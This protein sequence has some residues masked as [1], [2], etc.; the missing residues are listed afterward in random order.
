M[1]R[2]PSQVWM[3]HRRTG[4]EGQKGELALESGRVVFSPTGGADPTVFPIEDIR[5]AR[6]VIGSPVLELRLAARS[7]FRMV[8]FY[9]VQPPSL[10]PSDGT[11]RVMK[12]RAARKTAVVKLRTWNALK[13]DEIRDW[14][15]ELKPLLRGGRPA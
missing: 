8:G 12:R 9:F 15:R 10:D 14:V 7:E 4:P 6:R 11:G 2:E 5:G 3:V 1:E 13:K